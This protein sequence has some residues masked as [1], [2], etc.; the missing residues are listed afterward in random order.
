MSVSVCGAYTDVCAH[1]RALSVSSC[2]GV[3]VFLFGW[4]MYLSVSL[5]PCFP[6]SVSCSPVPLADPDAVPPP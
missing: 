6:I 5:S 3:S 4:S 1:L 2:L